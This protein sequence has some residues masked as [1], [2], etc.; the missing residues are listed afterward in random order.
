MAHHKETFWQNFRRFFFRG[1]AILLPS[2]LTFWL[3]IAAYN[4]VNETIAEPINA[5]VRELVV[6]FTPYPGIS[7]VERTSFKEAMDAK[8]FKAWKDSGESPTDMT[9]MVRRDKMLR[10]WR[11]NAWPLNLIGLFLAVMLIYLAGGFLG[12]FIGRRF[13]LRGE[14][15]LNKLP[16]LRSVYPSIKQVTDFLFGEK[17]QLQFS[18]AGQAHRRP[19]DQVLHPVE[20]CRPGRSAGPDFQNFGRPQHQYRFGVAEGHLSGGTAGGVGHHHAPRPGSLD[21]RG[22]QAGGRPGGGQPGQQHAAGGGLG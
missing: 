7:D 16:V 6:R 14:R 8:E 3:L 15:I 20:R 4:F 12:S 19:G 17:D 9:R 1:L 13:Y 5:G 18:R 11:N 10:L 2:V 21:D 22:L